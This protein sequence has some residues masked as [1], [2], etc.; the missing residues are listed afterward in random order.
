MNYDLTNPL[1]RKQFVRRANKMLKD[2]CHNAV[3]SNESKRSLNQNSYLHVLCRILA[4]ETGVTEKYAKEVY[5]KIMSNPDIFIKEDEDKLTGMR[6]QYIRSTA[7]LTSDEMSR[8]I[9]SFRRWS[10]QQGYYL[11]EANPDEAG[12]MVFVSDNDEKAF[13]QGEIESS[14]L[15]N[16]L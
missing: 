15:E 11:P 6:I 3:L 16:Y 8:A 10:E 12:N 13:R 1:H 14:R 4:I 5:F 7:D 9:N 2:K